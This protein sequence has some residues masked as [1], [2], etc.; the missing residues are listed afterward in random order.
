MDGRYKYTHLD[1]GPRCQLPRIKADWLE[2]VV[3][4]RLKDVLSNSDA[5]GRCIRD[6]LDELKERRKHFS[7]Q[8]C[9]VDSQIEIIRLKKERLGLVFA[10]GAISKDTYT[11]KLHN[12][13][14]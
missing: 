5:M 3:W 9:A 14:K 6:A 12:L 7:E 10:D 2:E 11:Q 4:N 1:G 8:T 13:N